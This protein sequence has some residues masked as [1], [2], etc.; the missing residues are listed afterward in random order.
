MCKQLLIVAIA[1]VKWMRI[2]IF[3]ENTFAVFFL[4]LDVV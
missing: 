1:F 3:N 2:S 4:F